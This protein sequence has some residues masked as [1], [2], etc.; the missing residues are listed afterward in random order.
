MS[1][2][3]TIGNAHFWKL[4]PTYR[5]Q[6]MCSTIIQAG[7]TFRNKSAALLSR[8]CLIKAYQK[9]ITMIDHHFEPQN[10]HQAN[11]ARPRN[12]DGCI[13]KIVPKALE[14]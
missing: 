3:G 4:V 9:L 7:F 14:A 6:S 2:D 11:A 8:I 12:H 13:R 1:Y 5:W 10:I